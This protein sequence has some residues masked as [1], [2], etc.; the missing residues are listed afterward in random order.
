[1]KSNGLEN[2]EK[3]RLLI[4]MDGTLAKFQQVDTLE[5]LYEKG[6][7]E[8]LEPITNVV[9]AVKYLIEN[10]P[11]IEVFIMS[12][13]LSDSKY[14]WEEKNLW[15]DRY[16]PEIDVEHRIFP[17]CGENK[18]D[19]VPDGIRENDVLLDDYTKN[20][21]LWE[22]PAKGIKLLNGINHTNGTW[23]GNMLR[24]DKTP[25]ELARDIVSIMQQGK[26]IQDVR[27]QEEKKEQLSQEP[28]EKVYRPAAK[29]VSGPRL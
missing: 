21:T 6:Y 2:G 7:F 11:E 27:P 17:A 8:N 12:A 29:K 5:T 4:D 15:L 10:H 26:L 18:L 25:E 19:Y 22:P 3:Q 24:Y 9:E 23:R 20:L 28:K 1:M 16:L 14:A 13:V